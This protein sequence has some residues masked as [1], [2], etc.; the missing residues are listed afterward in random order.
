[1]QSSCLW[2]QLAWSPTGDRLACFDADLGVRGELTIV[3]VVDKEGRPLREVRLPGLSGWSWSPTGRHAASIQRLD[4]LPQSPIRHIVTDPDG[5]VLATFAGAATTPLGYGTAWSPDGSSLAYVAPGP[6]IKAYEIASGRHRILYQPRGTTPVPIVILG[7]LGRGAVL[8]VA[9]VLGEDNLEGFH[10]AEFLLQPNTG[11]VTDLGGE[12][13]APGPF[14]PSPD[15]WA[16]V[17]SEP[18][19]LAVLDLRDLRA[20]TFGHSKVFPSEV[21]PF[22][23]AAAFSP[24]GSKL[25]WYEWATNAVYQFR[26]DGTQ[27][28]RLRVL[29]AE[30]NVLKFS[31]DVHTIAYSAGENPVGPADV[32]EIWVAGLRGN[33]A[34]RIVAHPNGI[35]RFEWR[36]GVV[37]AEAGGTR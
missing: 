27:P 4:R 3:V 37:R 18:S 21:L 19:R 25:Y 32:S 26:G 30:P 6:T 1:M 9:D 31:Q 14:H 5:H 22:D 36:P 16:L 35:A 13:P 28:R 15:G 17:W 2:G 12:L 34:R 20:V 10:L 29:P 11:K 33:D 23:E 24:D 7:W 8:L